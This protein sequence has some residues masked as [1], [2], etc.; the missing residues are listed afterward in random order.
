LTIEAIAVVLT[1]LAVYLTAR[2]IIWCWP[3]GMVSVVL[4]AVVFHHARLY[5]DM[6]LQGLYFALAAYGWWAW[7]HGGE[8]RGQLAVSLAK[9]RMRASV[10]VAATLG[11]I[12]L[13]GALTRFTNASLPFMDSL[14]TSFSIAGQWMQTRKL[15][16]SWLVWLAVDVLYVGM[17]LYKNLFLT[18]GLYA[19]FLV[20]AAMGFT[21]WRRS[22][23]TTPAPAPELAS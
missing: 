13:G 10:V 8:N 4:Y 18:A 2:E 20:L 12:L 11:G 15:L 7:L 23:R 14:L 3:L 9:P 19:V 22:M 21:H 6:G 17:F 5:A 1:L 16:E